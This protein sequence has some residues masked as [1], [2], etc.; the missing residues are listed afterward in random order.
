MF[1]DARYY[2]L[3]ARTIRLGAPYEIVE[4]SNIAH[5]AL[6]TPGYPLFLAACQASFG[7][8]PLAV[9]VVQAILGTL[10]VWLV[11]QLTRQIVA[12]PRDERRWSRQP[13]TRRWRPPL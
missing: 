6:R 5:R 3:L 11:Y 4:W 7:E 1:P 10:S 2:W 8:Q 13:G 12:K 9:R